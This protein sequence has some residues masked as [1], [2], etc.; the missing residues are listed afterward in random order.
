MLPQ[1]PQLIRSE[2]RYL[3]G[4]V[5]KWGLKWSTR[6]RWRW[7]RRGLYNMRDPLW[8]RGW[9]KERENTVATKIIFVPYC[10]QFIQVRPLWT[11]SP[12]ISESLIRVCLSFNSALA[13]VQ[14]IR[15]LFFD[16][17]SINLLYWAHWAEIPYILGLD[18][19]NVSLQ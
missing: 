2:R 18:T 17:L 8:E 13:I 12:L 16:P 7:S 10:V 11:E 1:L 4:R 9:E 19:K 5:L 3:M 14:L 15:A 6:V